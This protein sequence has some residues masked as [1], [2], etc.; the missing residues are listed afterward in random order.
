MAKLL[1]CLKFSGWNSCK[2]GNR[3]RNRGKED[4]KKHRNNDNFIIY[5]CL[6]VLIKII[7]YFAYFFYSFLYSYWISLKLF[8][9]VS[10]R[11][12]LLMKYDAKLH[13]AKKKKRYPGFLLGKYYKIMG[14]NN[15]D[16]AAPAQFI[17]TA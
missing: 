8:P 1:N 14:K 6:H 15:R 16:I 12:F 9:F 3:L 5:R 10:I 2:K 17:M 11:Y 13:K 7:H 4:K